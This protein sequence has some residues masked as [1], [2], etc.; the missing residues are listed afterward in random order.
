MRSVIRTT[1]V[2][3]RTRNPFAQPSGVVAIVGCGRCVWGGDGVVWA[4]V[5][6][7][8]R[9]ASD[10]DAVAGVAAGAHAAAQRQRRSTQARDTCHQ[11]PS[12]TRSVPR[13]PDDNRRVPATQG[14]LVLADISGYTKYMAGT[15]HEHSIEI[16]RELIET[17]ANSFEGRL[18]VDQLEGDALCAT[19]ERTDAGVLAWLHETFGLFHHRLRDIR[20]LSTCPCRACASASDLGLKFIVH[21]GEFSRQQIGSAVQLYGND[22]NLVHR[23]AKNTVPLREYVFAT[24]A[25][26]REW[27]NDPRDGFID[28]PQS[29]DVGVIAG[30]YAD[31]AQVKERALKDRVVEVRPED[32]KLHLRYEFAGPPEQVW[33]IL[34]E[35]QT[36]A[37]Y[38]GVP[39]VDLIPGAK[40]TYLGAEFHCRHGE[41][42]EGKTVFRITACEVPEFVTTYMEFPM[43]GHAYRTDRL[44]ANSTGT[45]NE[46]YVTWD[47]PPGPDPAGAD[48]EAAAMA[49]GF[50]DESAGRIADMIKE[51]VGAERSAASS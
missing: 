12:A 44:I 14:T 51:G 46:V 15:E 4:L 9:V 22:V 45:A 39:R 34:M 42:L 23:L 37:R 19:T 3:E 13:L 1:I 27:S 5:G 21:R 2:P 20:E 48:R 29:Y 49:K 31:L 7:P 43:I 32:A 33:R 35:P 50:F 41:N 16:L 40:G 26:L 24:D 11:Y 6:S 18:R 47:S 28:A 36:R 30:A 10:G 25:T 8:A 17:I 38:L